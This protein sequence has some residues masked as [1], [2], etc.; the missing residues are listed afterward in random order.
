M[1]SVP[2]G[3]SPI[4]PT[5]NSS[6][7]DITEPTLD[8]EPEKEQSE[9]LP[10]STCTDKPTDKHDENSADKSVVKQTDKPTQKEI[11][12]DNKDEVPLVIECPTKVHSD[13]KNFMITAIEYTSRENIPDKVDVDNLTE[14]SST[15]QREL[16]RRNIEGNFVR[17]LFVRLRNFSS[18]L[19]ISLHVF[20]FKSLYD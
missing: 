6:S 14:E 10:T 5:H 20:L 16:K 17:S 13:Y 7:T 11:E 15:P 3:D 4:T 2:I 12:D 9:I 19:K 18:S 1:L 8:R